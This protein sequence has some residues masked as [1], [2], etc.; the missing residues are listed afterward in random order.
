MRNRPDLPAFQQVQYAFAGYIRNP[1]ANPAPADVEARRMQL[2]AELFYNNLEEV[3]TSTFPILRSLLDDTRWHGLL[4]DYLARHRATAPLFYELPREFLKYLEQEREPSADDYPFLTELAHYEWVELAL[5]ISGQSD[6]MQAV[7]VNGDLLEGVPVLSALA[8]PLHYAFPVHRISPEFVPAEP[9]PQATHLLAYRDSDDAVG[10]IDMN[11]VT[12]R[13]VHLIEHNDESSGRALL[14][15][16][17][18]EL[19]HPNP[20]VVMEGGTQILRDLKTRGALA[21]TRK[22]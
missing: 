22:F 18:E 7:D 9:P 13:L 12:A 21:G 5:A 15:T 11:P 16:I 17:A 3:I 2:Y 20:A 1:D 4:R 8:W 19:H 14:V 6:N 10:F